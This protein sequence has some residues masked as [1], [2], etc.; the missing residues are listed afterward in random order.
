MFDMKKNFGRKIAILTVAGLFMSGISSTTM[1]L[2]AED[3]LGALGAKTDQDYTLEEML[4]YA[5]EDEYLAQA[6]Y[7][8]IMETY[9]VIK[10]YSNISKAEATHIEL[11]EPLFEQYE[12]T[13]PEKDWDSYV[14]L[15]DTLQE[16]YEI[17]VEAELNNIAMYE[18]FL[19]E[20]L[21]DEVRT[22][23]EALKN[24]SEKH[25]QA[26]QRKV[27]GVVGNGTGTGTG[28]GNGNGQRN[29]S[30]KGYCNT[31]QQNCIYN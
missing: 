5:M 11:L 14:V 23:F 10:P 7:E 4:L 6:E 13:V 16:T 8:K 30:S 20:E 1:V 2:A 28:T 12:V 17:G 15:P 26:F 24:A 9:G 31:L 18:S 29:N 3:Q 21:P 22:V 25:L 19:E 27:D